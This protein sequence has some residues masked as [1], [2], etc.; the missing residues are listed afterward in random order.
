MDTYTVLEAINKNG[1]D[2]INLVPWVTPLLHQK[3]S[4]LHSIVKY[5]LI[6]LTVIIILQFFDSF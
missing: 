4:K 1:K 5:K 6:L 2:L 3:K